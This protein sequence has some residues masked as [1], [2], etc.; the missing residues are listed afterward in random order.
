MLDEN[1]LDYASAI[2][3]GLQ[4]PV[5]FSKGYTEVEALG[6][7]DNARAKKRYG[8]RTNFLKY[9]VSNYLTP[10]S[11]KG[12]RPMPWLHEFYDILEQAGI[13]VKDDIKACHEFYEDREIHVEFKDEVS[14]AMG[15]PRKTREIPDENSRLLYV[16]TLIFYS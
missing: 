3:S 1:A 5:S 4:N 13:D 14:K 8:P 12:H 9:T 15:S 2:S 11:G 16:H 7:L 10:V 6:K